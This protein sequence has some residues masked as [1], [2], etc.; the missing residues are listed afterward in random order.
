MGQPAVSNHV[1]C[2][3]FPPGGMGMELGEIQAGPVAGSLVSCHGDLPDI[4]YPM[5][6][7]PL[8]SSW[9]KTAILHHGGN[10]SGCHIPV[11]GWVPDPGPE[12][13]REENI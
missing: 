1:S 4:L 2:L 5:V 13:A 12:G 11:P 6:S 7:Q 8:L 10:I 3:A 9:R